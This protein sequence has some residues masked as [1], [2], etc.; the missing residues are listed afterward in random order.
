MDFIQLKND[1]MKFEARERFIEMYINNDLCELKINK[2]D[3]AFNIIDKAGRFA[4]IDTN[5][6]YYVMRIK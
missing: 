4:L 1:L 3:S 5:N 2:I 6:S